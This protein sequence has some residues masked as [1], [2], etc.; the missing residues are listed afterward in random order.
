MFLFKNFLRVVLLLGLS[1]TTFSSELDLLL[2]LKGEPAPGALMIGRTLPG[3]DVYLGADPLKISDEGWFVFGFGRDDAGDKAL[4]L[5]RDGISQVK[6]LSLQSREWNIQRVEGVPQETVTPPKERLE[7]IRKETAL[8]VVA[9]RPYSQ[10][11]GFLE[12]F[13]WPASG[14]VSGVYGSQ[15][16]YNGVAGRPHYGVDIAAPTGTPVYAPAGGMVTLNH[17]D[18]F[19]SGGTLI[20]DHGM[21]IFSTFIHLD[22][23]LVEKGQQVKQGDLIGRIG[24]S[25]RATGPHLDWRINWFSQRLDPQW[26]MGGM[27]L[28]TIQSPIDYP[29]A[30]LTSSEMSHSQ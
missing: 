5:K 6:T 3:V 20:M 16:Y 1:A 9:R 14:R 27:D 26:F 19:Y 10:L 17:P 11:Q 18:M 15:R 24:S 25:G 30:E 21:G 7:R 23:V 4:T 12:S 29:K 13:I 22:E 28:S 2:E 8:V